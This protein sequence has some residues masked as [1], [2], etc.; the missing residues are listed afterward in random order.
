MPRWIHHRQEWSQWALLKD[1][2]GYSPRHTAEA[3]LTSSVLNTTLYLALILNLGHIFDAPADVRA[4]RRQPAAEFS[5]AGCVE[6]VTWLCVITIIDL[7]LYIFTKY[8]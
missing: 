6:N 1:I 5:Q 8:I 4:Q 7:L 2:C 3:S